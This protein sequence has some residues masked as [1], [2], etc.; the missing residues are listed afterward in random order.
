MVLA[1][2]EENAPAGAIQAVRR[3]DTAVDLQ[4]RPLDPASTRGVAALY[5]DTEVSELPP[6]MLES[7]GGVPRR[8]H[9]VVSNWA[10]DRAT[11]R[12]GLLASQAAG[13]RTEAASGRCSRTARSSSKQT[14]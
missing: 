1:L 8:V 3:L 9:E 2:D 12:L 7:T 6:G 10:E 14:S 4:L 11:R 5:L 13:S